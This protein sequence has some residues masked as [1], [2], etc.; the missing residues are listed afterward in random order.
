M[1]GRVELE[2][3]PARLEDVVGQ[4]LDRR[5]AA[6]LGRERLR[7]PYDREDV[8]I[9][10]DDPESIPVRLW[11]SIHGRVAQQQ[12]EQLP[13]LMVGEQIVIEQ[14]GRFET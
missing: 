11:V 3:V 6:D 13:R 8:V 2:E 7:I 4:V 1:L 14:V 12:V 9:A 10:G 5:S